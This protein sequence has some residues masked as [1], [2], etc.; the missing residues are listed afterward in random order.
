[1]FS[2]VTDTLGPTGV[3]LLAAG[4]SSRMGRPKLLLPWGK[5]SILGYLIGQWTALG[6]RQISV[7]RAAQDEV[8]SAE[9]D[10]LGFPAR[11][12]ISN[13]DPD[14]GMFSSIQCA[15]QWPRWEKGLTHWVIALGDQPH[16]RIETLRTILDFVAEHSKSI[17]IP[18]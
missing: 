11:N 7:V 17:C 15:A 18:R 16:L 1:M 14:R 3:V 4:A 8:I 6:V 5:T 10:R 9:L 2:E 13:P 12:R